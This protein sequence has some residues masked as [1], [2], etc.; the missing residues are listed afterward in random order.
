MA[1]LISDQG[2][3]RTREVARNKEGHYEIIKGSIQEAAVTI[4]DAYTPKSRALE[5]MEQKPGAE[6]KSTQTGNHS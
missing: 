3:F 2:N 6:K 1:I 5:H 4:P